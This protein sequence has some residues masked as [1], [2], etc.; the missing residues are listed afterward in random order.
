MRAAHDVV[1]GTGYDG[2]DFL[3][4]IL[5]AISCGGSVLPGWSWRGRWNWRR[6]D[7]SGLIRVQGPDAIEERPDDSGD[8]KSDSS[9]TKG[10]QHPIKG[11]TAWAF[12]L[13]QD[14]ER[15]HNVC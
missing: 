10:A 15:V 14:E 11:G 1:D 13:G 4:Y 8:T 5:C 7:T 3:R 2:D 9:D 12:R 6:N